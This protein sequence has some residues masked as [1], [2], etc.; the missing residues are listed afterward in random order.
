MLL[1]RRKLKRHYPQK[2]GGVGMFVVGEKYRRARD[3][4]DRYGGTRQSGIS[5]S[6]SNPFIFLFTGESGEAY[7]YED[8]WQQDD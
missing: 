4:H 1:S 7:G 3:I 8:G 6:A 2:A 5:A